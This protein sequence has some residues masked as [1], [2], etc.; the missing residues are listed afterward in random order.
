MG[1]APYL[2]HDSNRTRTAPMILTRTEAV[3]RFFRACRSMPSPLQPCNKDDQALCMAWLRVKCDMVYVQHLSFSSVY[4]YESAK[5]GPRM[6]FHAKLYRDIGSFVTAECPDVLKLRQDLQKS[7]VRASFGKPRLTTF[8]AGRSS[9]A[10][11]PELKPWPNGMVAVGS[12]QLPRG[13]RQSIS[14]PGLWQSE[15]R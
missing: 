14:T 10:G 5:G 8:R 3:P 15:P 1:S 11:R 2:E 6:V 4:E 12:I 7:L 13:K 9:L